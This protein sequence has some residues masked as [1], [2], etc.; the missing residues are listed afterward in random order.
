MN[1]EELKILWN[2][3]E[4]ELDQERLGREEVLTLLKG[5]GRKA[6]SRINRNIL[7]EM[8][9]VAL[10]GVFWIFALVSSPE[11]ASS[12][13]IGSVFLYVILSALFY[14]WKFRSLNAAKLEGKD[15]KSALQHTVKIMGRFMRIY[16]WAGWILIPILG[17]AGFVQGVIQGLQEAGASL[18][19]LAPGRLLLMAGVLLLYN[20]LA[21]IF[22]R[23]YVHKLYGK[24]YG[25]LKGALS[26]LEETP[27][28]A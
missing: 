9:V 13:E 25:I 18:S 14:R 28:V 8:G 7:L 16:H 12:L 5:K 4:H 27:G 22:V 11:P 23:W 2:S 10:F 24:N 15:L 3:Q 17:T 1:L 6:L 21:V 19:E 26:E 20:V